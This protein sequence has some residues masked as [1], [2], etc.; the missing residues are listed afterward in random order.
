MSIE[1]E[2]KKQEEIAMVDKVNAEHASEVTA[3]QDLREAFNAE[4]EEK[5][6]KDFWSKM[7]DYDN[8]YQKV[9]NEGIEDGDYLL[10]LVS[11][12]LSR[13][14]KG[15]E[16]IVCKWQLEESYIVDDVEI[17]KLK[18]TTFSN[19]QFYSGLGTNPALR[20]LKGIY[21]AYQLPEPKVFTINDLIKNV[22][23]QVLK[24]E[25]IKIVKG[26]VTSQRSG[27]ATFNQ[28]AL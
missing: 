24:Q 1:K 11:I 10:S 13:T 18:F 7:T 26:R 15:D 2:I 8:A 20:L 4:D 14:R 9:Y 3:K 23:D 12:R 27:G 21:R 16:Q 6:Y 5:R 19:N 28:V 17:N 22:E 25:K